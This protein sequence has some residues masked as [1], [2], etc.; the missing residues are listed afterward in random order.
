VVNLELKRGMGRKKLKRFHHSTLV[1]SMKQR[2]SFV[3]TLDRP[4]P[5]VNAP[6]ASNDVAS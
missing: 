5:S 4:M 1:A 2:S 3:D 6:R